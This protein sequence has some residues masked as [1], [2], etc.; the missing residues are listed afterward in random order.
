MIRTQLPIPRPILRDLAAL[1]LLPAV[2]W[3]GMA[4]SQPDNDSPAEERPAEA[5]RTAS[6]E[7]GSA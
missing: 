6:A 4:C 1:I 3:L 5:V 7:G 2:G